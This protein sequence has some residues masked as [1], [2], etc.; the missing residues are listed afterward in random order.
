MLDNCEELLY[1]LV[2]AK[3]MPL[4]AETDTFRP[5]HGIHLSVKRTPTAAPGAGPRWQI[6]HGAANAYLA[7]W[8]S[9]PWQEAAEH[10]HSAYRAMLLVLEAALQAQDPSR[11]IYRRQEAVALWEKLAHDDV[12]PV[13]AKPISAIKSELFASTSSGVVASA[14]PIRQADAATRLHTGRVAGQIEAGSPL[15]LYV[16]NG[17]RRYANR[18]PAVRAVRLVKRKKR[19]S[20]KAYFA[21]VKQLI[22]GIVAAGGTHLLI[23]PERVNWLRKQPLLVEYFSNHHEV[24]LASPETGIVFEL[25]SS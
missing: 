11:L 13:S 25:R 23:P 8:E 7:L 9:A 24:V 16:V 17:G 14:R 5:T 10:F 12:P 3:G 20:G 2:L 21:R 6:P 18:N 22:E 15:V 1:R 19:Q 4:P